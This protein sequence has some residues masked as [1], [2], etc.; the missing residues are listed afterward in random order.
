MTPDEIREYAERDWSAIEREKA[1]YWADRKKSLSAIDALRIGD[2]LRA[3]ARRLH[4][5]WPAAAD[6]DEDLATHRR[7]SEALRSV[8]GTHRR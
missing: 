8:A 7:V 6:R 1:R 2:E 5:D 4:P 3:H